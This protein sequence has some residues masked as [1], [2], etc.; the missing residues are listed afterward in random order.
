M[1]DKTHL[2]SPLGGSYCGLEAYQ[3]Y[4][5]K[6]PA[7]VG[8]RQLVEVDCE[9]CLHRGMEDCVDQSRALVKRRDAMAEQFLELERVR[10]NQ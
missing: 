10:S 3:I 2:V 5:V 7:L 1:D 6:G 9:Q 8:L 4:T